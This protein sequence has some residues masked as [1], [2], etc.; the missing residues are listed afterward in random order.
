[1]AYLELADT[2]ENIIKSCSRALDLGAELAFSPASALG[3]GDPYPVDTVVSY[4]G[5]DRPIFKGVVTKASRTV[6]DESVTYTCRS[7]DQYLEGLP[8]VPKHTDYNVWPIPLCS[9]TKTDATIGDFVTQECSNDSANGFTTQVVPG[10][11]TEVVVPDSIKD[12]LAGSTT[13]HQKSFLNSLRG[14]LSPYPFIKLVIEFSAVVSDSI[15]PVGKLVLV[16]TRAGS[17]TV[18]LEVG[19]ESSAILNQPSFEVETSESA[20]TVNIYGR[21]L[22]VEREEILEPAWDQSNLTFTRAV[23]LSTPAL[24]ATGKYSQS[25]MR[26]ASQVIFNSEPVIRVGGV[27][28]FPQA[29]YTIDTR[30]G[31]VSWVFDRLYYVDSVTGELSNYLGAPAPG[32]RTPLAYGNPTLSGATITMEFEALNPEAFR[33]YKT[34]RPI[35]LTKMARGLVADP[36]NNG[37]WVEDAVES[38]EGPVYCAIPASLI[39]VVEGDERLVVGSAEIHTEAEWAAI[40]D[41]LRTPRGGSS[42]T[43]T[44][45]LVRGRATLVAASGPDAAYYRPELYD[46]SKPAVGPVFTEESTFCLSQTTSDFEVVEGGRCIMFSQPQAAAVWRTVKNSDGSFTNVRGFQ[47][48]EVACRYTSWSELKETRTSTLGK[49]RTYNGVLESAFKYVNTEGTVIKDLSSSLVEAADAA[50]QYSDTPNA[51]GN[52]EVGC[53]WDSEALRWVVPVSVGDRVSLSGSVST[54]ITSLTFIVNSVDYSPLDEGGYVKVSL[55]RKEPRKNPFL[56]AAP[57]RVQ[58]G[59][60][61]ETTEVSG[62]VTR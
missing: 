43:L 9:K 14:A 60:G 58:L 33:K 1:M 35:S 49:F 54:V 56:P 31:V 26:F 46:P 61:R 62:V 57:K 27:R 23:N 40:D 42:P 53:T 59:V 12:L 25:F 20:E 30:S 10:W 52:L 45:Q 51:T 3:D 36:L 55:G 29:D 21:G 2:P 11:F 15:F 32:K 13:T 50:K 48:W 44:Y 7:A 41:S 38:P 28:A 18:N 24:D 17:R 5:S 47:S 37:S 16:D 39:S 19:G 4:S 6:G 22:L 34:S 8:W